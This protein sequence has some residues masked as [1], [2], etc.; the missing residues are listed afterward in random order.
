MCSCWPVWSRAEADEIVGLRAWSRPL[1]L[2]HRVRNLE[3]L[4]LQ[5]HQAI[6]ASFSFFHP[7]QPLMRVEQGG[8]KIERARDLFEQALE[9]CPAKFAK[10]LYLMYGKMEEEHGLAKRAMSVYDRATQAVENTDRMEVRRSPLHPSSLLIPARRCSPTTSPKLPPTLVSPP[11]ARF[12]SVRS[13][14]SPTSKRPRC[15]FASRRSNAS[16]A[17]STARA[18]SLRTLVSSA[19]LGCVRFFAA[20]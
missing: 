2:P 9:N 8:D 20:R 5:V 15:A 10:P 17:R 12:T 11:R 6:R 14:A 4:P 3:H 16:S 1:H 7:S 18:P 13:R 19:T